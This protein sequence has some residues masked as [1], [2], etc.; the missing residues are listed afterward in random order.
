MPELSD[1]DK[2]LDSPDPVERKMALRQPDL[3]EHHLWRALQDPD[4]GVFT[5]AS[6]HP[7][8]S[9]AQ[10]QYALENRSGDPSDLPI[11]GT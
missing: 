10:L 7:S 9:S 4:R 1:I 5:T 8:L 6:S 3:S 2:L 11:F